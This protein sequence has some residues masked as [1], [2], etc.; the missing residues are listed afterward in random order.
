[1]RLVVLVR[2]ADRVEEVGDDLVARAGHADVAA[3]AE[4]R[5]DHARPAVGLSRPGRAL[6]GEHAVL[7]AERGL[8]G[9]LEQAGG[10]RDVREGTSP[11]PRPPAGPTNRGGSA[12]RS[13]SDAGLQAASAS[14]P[15]ISRRASCGAGPSASVGRH[16]LVGEQG[17]ER[18]GS[19][20]APFPTLRSI[21]RSPSSIPT[22][23]PL[24][25]G[26]RI[27]RVLPLRSAGDPARGTGTGGW[28][29]SSS[30]HDPHVLEP[31]ERLRLL[32]QLVDREV[33]HP[34]VVPPRALVLAPVPLE[35]VRR[36]PAD[37]LFGG[38]GV[39]A[40]TSSRSRRMSSATSAATSSSS[41]S[42]GSGGAGGGIGS[43]RAASTSARSLSSQSRSAR[44][45]TQS[46]RLY[47][48]T[49][50]RSS[51]CSGR[52]GPRWRAPARAAGA[53]A[54]RR[55]AG[56]IARTRSAARAS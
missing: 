13:A 25:L 24:L 54:A 27:L 1:V 10:G 14:S 36:E 19:N 47:P 28:S 49:T 43:P 20:S 7:E 53:P 33:A 32:D 4:Q 39:S 9:S 22:T 42:F 51:S 34:E 50:G 30:V 8:D 55:R 6:H 37:L 48:W 16:D 11:A 40:E 5:A 18:V 41:S 21:V 46:S 38:R 2:L 3:L 15:S 44:V 29:T 12:R 56:R 17:A 45:E 52:R 35:Q 31:R 23:L 26:L